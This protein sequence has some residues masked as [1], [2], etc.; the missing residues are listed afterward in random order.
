M[1]GKRKAPGQL[2]I[3]ELFS[4]RKRVGAEEPDGLVSRTEEISVGAATVPDD[5]WRSGIE[6]DV[7]GGYNAEAACQLQSKL[8]VLCC[9][10]LIPSNLQSCNFHGRITALNIYR[11]VTSAKHVYINYS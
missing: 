4:P 2:T 8:T 7:G 10:G 6:N 3:S 11:K 5:A 1:S 9:S